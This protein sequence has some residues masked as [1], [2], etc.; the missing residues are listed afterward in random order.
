MRLKVPLYGGPFD[1]RE[2]LVDDA[3]LS[4]YKFAILYDLTAG[5][6]PEA[7]PMTDE[8]YIL[9]ILEGAPANPN[10]DDE[11]D[12]LRMPSTWFA[13]WAP[14]VQPQVRAAIRR[15]QEQGP[16]FEDIERMRLA[17]REAEG[18]LLLEPCAPG[19]HDWTEW[20]VTKQGNSTRS[21]RR[22]GMG[23]GSIF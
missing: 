9:G 18:E 21:C 20:R 2:A 8:P 7:E 10:E 17:H 12:A 14:L 11:P 3:D 19:T 23:Q 16:D 15:R 22:C 5:D 1:G 4:L 6:D 13:V